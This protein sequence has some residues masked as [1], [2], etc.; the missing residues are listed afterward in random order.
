MGLRPKEVGRRN[1]EVGKRDVELRTQLQIAYEIGYVDNDL[2]HSFDD[3]YERPA[4]MIVALI[5]ARRG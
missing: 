3:R 4:K 2:F 1:A 5:K